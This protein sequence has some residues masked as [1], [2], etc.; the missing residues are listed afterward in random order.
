MLHGDGDLCE[1]LFKLIIHLILCDLIQDVIHHLLDLSLI[2]PLCQHIQWLRDVLFQTFELGV[3]IR[4]Y[5]LL[6]CGLDIL[7]LLDG[8]IQL[9]SHDTYIFFDFGI[10]NRIEAI[11]S[12]V[13]LGEDGIVTTCTF[14][15]F[16]VHEGTSEGLE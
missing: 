16:F 15:Y 11:E 5:L 8:H 1:R 3:H 2:E 4:G 12:L 6:Q 7:C 13:D 10:E 14:C 9:I